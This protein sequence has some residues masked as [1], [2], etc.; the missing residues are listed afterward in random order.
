MKKFYFCKDENEWND[1]VNCKDKRQNPRHFHE[2][3]YALRK[4]FDTELKYVLSSFSDIKSKE[5]INAELISFDPGIEYYPESYWEISLVFYTWSKGVIYVIY[6][7]LTQFCKE[8]NNWF[9]VSIDAH[10]MYVYLFPESDVLFEYSRRA[11]DKVK[12]AN[13]ALAL[14]KYGLGDDDGNTLLVPKPVNW[15]EFLSLK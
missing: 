5:Y 14:A 1:I 15:P 6:D 3:D 12:E 7:F 10:P 11:K 13:F 8:N 2:I 4:K 9:S